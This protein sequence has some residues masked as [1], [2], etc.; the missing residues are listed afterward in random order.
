ME[1][2]PWFLDA[3]LLMFGQVAGLGVFFVA[4]IFMVARRRLAPVAPREKFGS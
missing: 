2:A 1:R 3:Q 4:L